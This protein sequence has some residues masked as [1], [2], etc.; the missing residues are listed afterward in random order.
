MPHPYY[1]FRT[2]IGHLTPGYPNNILTFTDSGGTIAV[3]VF[4]ADLNLLWHHT[5]DCK[6]DHLGHYVYPVDINGDGLD[7]VIIGSIVLDSKGKVLWHLLDEF[8]DHHDHADS[9]R[10][11]DID[12]DG[13]MEILAPWSEIGVLALKADTGKLLW[14][15]PAE[16]VQQLEFGNFLGGAAAPQVA[17][18]ARF[19][20][21]RESSEPYLSAQV[22]WFDAK[23]KLVGKWPANPLNGNPD[24]VKGDWY[25]N[26]KD[27]LFWYRFKMNTEGKGHLF[28]DQPAYHMFDFAGRG[29]EEVVTVGRDIVKIYGYRN[30][31]HRKVVRDIEYLR[32]KVANHTHY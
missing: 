16:H 28:F 17:A 11:G 29:A 24:F 20:G 9:Y 7:E 22:H 3:H 8:P 19:Y 2:A 14:Q 32:N 10:F 13:K 25:G 15:H 4:D 23:G 26:G 1:N 12:G 18:N 31:T 30:V 21:K 27:E 5:E 6:K